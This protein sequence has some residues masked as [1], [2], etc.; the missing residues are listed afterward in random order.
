VVGA[1]DEKERPV[2]LTKTPLIQPRSDATVLDVAGGQ[3]SV[4]LRDEQTGGQLALIENVIPAGYQDLPLHVHPA[5]DEAFYV[6]DGTLRFHVGDEVLTATPGTLVYAPGAVP[7]NFAN[8]SGEQ[9]RMPS[10]G[11]ACGPRAVLDAVAQAAQAAPG[12]WPMA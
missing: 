9:A 2:A 6:L 1:P 7:H 12:G 3:I 5:F 8:F 10:L 4:R 11:D